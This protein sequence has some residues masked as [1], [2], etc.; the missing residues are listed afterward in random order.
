MQ[1]NL[2]K[3][4]A[5][6]LPPTARWLGAAGVLP[7]P[8]GAAVAVVAGGNAAALALQGLVGYALAITCFLCGAWWGIALLRR[9]P[10]LL[11][12]SNGIVVAAWA[13]A[14]LLQP[15]VSLPVLALLLAATVCVEGRHWAFAPQPA[16]YRRLRMR[17]TVVAA[18]CLLAAAV[19]S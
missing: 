3:T 12:A 1:P 16:Y 5:A 17:L 14:W 18:V 10:A 19:L 7:F 11:L 15:A 9:A 4:G 13:A 2:E 8:G 6:R